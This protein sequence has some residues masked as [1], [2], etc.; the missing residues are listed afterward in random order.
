MESEIEGE[1]GVNPRQQEWIWEEKGRRR[2]ELGF[3]R[4]TEAME[5]LKKED[6]AGTK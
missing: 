5:K 4:A 2:L 1:A 3:L 6:Q